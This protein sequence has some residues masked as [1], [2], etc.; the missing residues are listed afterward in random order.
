MPR[1][2]DKVFCLYSAKQPR[3]GAVAPI[4]PQHKVVVRAQL[5]IKLVAVAAICPAAQQRCRAIHRV[6][7]TDRVLTHMHCLAWQA[8]DAFDIYFNTITLEFM[9]RIAKNKKLAASRCNYMQRERVNYHNLA[10]F[11]RRIH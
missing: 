7:D 1:P 6:V 8:Y 9:V 4:V 2:A 10:I 3:V 11:K 5:H